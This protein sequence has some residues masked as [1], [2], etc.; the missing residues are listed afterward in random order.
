ML[1]KAVQQRLVVCGW[2]R[3][4]GDDA[5]QGAAAPHEEESRDG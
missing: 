2:Y 4:Q 3:G 5:P 1:G